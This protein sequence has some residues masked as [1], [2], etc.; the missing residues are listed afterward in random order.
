MKQRTFF[1]TLLLFLVFLNG[2]LCVMLCVMLK[3]R[4]AGA[5]ERALSEQYMIASM[6]FK[7]MQAFEERGVL[8]P[9][10]LKQ[11]LQQYGGLLRSQRTSLL[12]YEGD[13]I[14]FETGEPEEA[15][16]RLLPEKAPNARP[17]YRDTG[18]VPGEQAMYYIIGRLPSPYDS[19]TLL[20]SS[21]LSEE[22]RKW[23]ELRFWLF[24]GGTAVSFVLAGCL[25]LLIQNI[26]RPLSEI[27]EISGEIADG[28]YEKRLPSAGRDELAQVAYSFNHMA[29]KIQEQIAALDATARQKQQF[30]DN[31]AHELKTPLTAIYGYAE[32]LQKAICSEQDRQEALSYIMSECRRIQQMERQLLDLALLR[33]GSFQ[34]E[35][36]A[37]A[38]FFA[39]SERILQPRALEKK[40]RLTYRAE[41]SCLY[42]NR[43]LLQHLLTNLV[44]NAIQSCAEGGA[45]TVRAYQAPKGKCILISDDGHGMEAGEIEHIT[46]AFYRVDKSRSREHGGAGLGLAICSQIAE[47]E[48]IRLRF[49]SVPEVGTN[50]FLNFTS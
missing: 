6:M 33:E 8:S 19:Y 20:Y 13:S 10:N 49:D 22:T 16:R 21:D 28:Q 27:S 5:K 26:F 45:V 39:E 47:I 7:D 42:A 37:T 46:E 9:E 17:Q 23:K 15:V 40:I 29:D 24:T 44:M 34:K 35:K 3:D 50:V 2:I 4:L 41:L 31:F 38:D 14:V 32:Y 11:G 36:I 18:F 1:T 25:L 43:G 30:I 12:L 48:Q